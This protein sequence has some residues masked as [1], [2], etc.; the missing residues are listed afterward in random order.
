ML[1]EEHVLEKREAMWG[2]NKDT[3]RHTVRDYRESLQQPKDYITVN[4]YHSL[5]INKELHG[6]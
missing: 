5:T 1:M 3:I 6:I 2:G 4:L